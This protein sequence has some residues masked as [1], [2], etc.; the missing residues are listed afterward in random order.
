MLEK[1]AVNEVVDMPP[2]KKFFRVFEQITIHTW[3]QAFFT[4]ATDFVAELV[5]NVPVKLLRCRPDE[6][7]ME[8][9][10][11]ALRML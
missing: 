11:E 1:A 4:A 3:H 6:G 10:R 8:A 9:V 7:A 5:Q 2:S